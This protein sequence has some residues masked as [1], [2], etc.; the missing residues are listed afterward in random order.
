MFHMLASF[1]VKQ[2]LYPAILIRLGKRVMNEVGE[3]T[4]VAYPF[5]RTH[6]FT[7]SE[8]ENTKEIVVIGFLA[9]I[10]ICHK[11][12]VQSTNPSIA[13]CRRKERIFF[14]LDKQVEVNFWV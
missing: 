2:F 1:V 10:S 11:L 4:L 8:I 7:I 14:G 6:E 5:H 13:V 3:V 12:F 9:Y